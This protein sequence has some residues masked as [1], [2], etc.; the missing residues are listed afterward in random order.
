[1]RERKEER[2]EG[3]KRWSLKIGRRGDWSSIYPIYLASIP[4]ETAQPHLVLDES[5]IRIRSHH[6][7]IPT[8]NPARTGGR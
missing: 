8:R 7:R 5:C 4:F 3:R 2:K 1:V 6:T